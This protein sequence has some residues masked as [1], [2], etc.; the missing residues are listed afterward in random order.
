M[1]SK[2]KFLLDENVRAELLDFLRERSVDAKRVP[3][4]VSN[5]RAA[6]LSAREGRVLVTNDSDF[7]SPS[8]R[9]KMF[10]LALLK[11]PQNRP[12]LLLAAFSS[13]L[14]N[15]PREMKGRAFALTEEGLKSLE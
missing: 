15:P 2:P 1:G 6:E 11:L 4:G 12:D 3:S 13:L 7:A 14:E 10:A 5:G 9:G 8:L